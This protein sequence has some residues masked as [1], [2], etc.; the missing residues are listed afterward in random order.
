MDQLRLNKIN[1][2][3]KSTG[4][5]SMADY[6]FGSKASLSIGSVERR[7]SD[8]NADIA[9]GSNERPFMADF[10]LSNSN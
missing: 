3:G 4:S 10:S 1:T 5:N 9:S 8:Q 2:I 7:L 6:G